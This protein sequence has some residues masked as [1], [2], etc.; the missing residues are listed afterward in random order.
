MMHKR[1]SSSI[2]N[3]MNSIDPSTISPNL[4]GNLKL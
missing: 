3:F 1:S 2:N 4:N